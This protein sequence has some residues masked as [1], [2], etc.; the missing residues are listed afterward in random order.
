MKSNEDKNNSKIRSQLIRHTEVKVEVETEMCFFFQEDKCFAH[1]PSM[2]S[3]RKK[4]EFVLNKKRRATNT[5]GELNRQAHQMVR[6]ERNQKFI[7]EKIN[8]HC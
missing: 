1:F 5:R 3:E 7:T 8:I 6:L 4:H 2:V